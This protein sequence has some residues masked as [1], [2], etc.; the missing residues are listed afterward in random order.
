MATFTS[1]RN[2]G[3][4]VNSTAD[5]YHPTMLWEEGALIYL[6]NFIEDPD[7]YPDFFIIPLDL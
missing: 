2:L 5:D 4:C 7:W 6:R 3:P 1:A